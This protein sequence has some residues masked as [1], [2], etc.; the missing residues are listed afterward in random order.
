LEFRNRKQSPP[1]HQ[2]HDHTPHENPDKE[3]VQMNNI[4]LPIVL[5]P[6]TPKDIE[7]ALTDIRN[8]TNVYGRW[9]LFSDDMKNQDDANAEADRLWW[10]NIINPEGVEETAC[11]GG[12]TSTEAAAVTWINTCLCAWWRQPGLSEED[13]AKVPRHGLKAGSSSCTSALVKPVVS[14]V[15]S[16]PKTPQADG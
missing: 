12:I 5:P 1:I 3:Q 11:G 8:G 9:I 16:H 2:T 6:P 14:H 10:V 15:H 13:D 7:A 4:V